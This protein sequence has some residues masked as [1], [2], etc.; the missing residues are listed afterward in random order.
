MGRGLH[1]L[2]YVGDE[3]DDSLHR[4]THQLE[5]ATLYPLFLIPGQV[6]SSV[7]SICGIEH[8]DAQPSALLLHITHIQEFQ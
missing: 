7:S 4:T 8:I 2:K 6:F 3:S 1:A 5:V